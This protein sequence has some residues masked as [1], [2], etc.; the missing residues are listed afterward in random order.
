M[1]YFLSLLAALAVAGIGWSIRR[2][3]ALWGQGLI[4]VGC[5]GCLAAIGWQVRENLFP[6]GAKPPNRAHSVV[7][8]Y[9]ASQAQRE[10]AGQRGTVVL[11][12][13]PS[14]TLDAETA[15]TYANAFRAPLLRGHPELEVQIATL[16]APAREAKAGTIPLAA[17]KRVVASFPGALA[18]VCFASVPPDIGTLF[19][20]DQAASPPL[21]V[22]DA[23]GT[24]N[25][26]QALLQRRIR[27]VIVP[28]PEVDPAAMTSIAGMPGEIFGRLYYLATPETAEQISAKLAGNPA[29]TPR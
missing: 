27:S 19:P 26:V 3:S 28:R 16:E 17:F 2:R 25:W 9:L 12:L 10:I 18:F 4:A 8:F 20:P 5:V 11:V 21:F 15:E 13:P 22:F 1:M 23:G 6:A 24:T 29:P 14:S 7:G